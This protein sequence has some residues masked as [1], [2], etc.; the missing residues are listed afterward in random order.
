[1]KRIFW[2][3]FSQGCETETDLVALMDN[4]WGE[5]EGGSAI[6]LVILDLSVAFNIFYH[7]LL[8]G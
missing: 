7:G 1:M 4:L 5:Q 6:I 2:T 8:L 3:H